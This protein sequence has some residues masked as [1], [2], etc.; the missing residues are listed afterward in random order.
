MMA[1]FP[2][3]G[4]PTEI[5]KS[6]FGGKAQYGKAINDLETELFKQDQPA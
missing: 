6:I 5:I 2:Q 4:T 1:P 3:I